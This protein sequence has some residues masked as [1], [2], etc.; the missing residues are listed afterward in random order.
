M[1]S[2]LCPVHAE[3]ATAVAAAAP[4]AAP[5]A[6]APPSPK[7]KVEPAEQLSS[8]ATLDELTTLD[9]LL[10]SDDSDAE[11]RPRGCR[12]ARGSTTS[13]GRGGGRGG[14]GRGGGRGVPKTCRTCKAPL[15]GGHVCRR[16]G[17]PGGGV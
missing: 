4:A 14:T 17:A 3:A 5:T 15:K 16:P 12:A 7:I 1:V 2:V 13:G 6:P 11:W 8:W 10:N 9:E